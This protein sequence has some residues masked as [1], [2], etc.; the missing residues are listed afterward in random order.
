LST[1]EFFCRLYTA[2]CT[3]EEVRRSS[4]RHL[5]IRQRAFERRTRRQEAHLVGLRNE[6]RSAFGAD[7][8]DPYE[9]THH[10]QDTDASEEAR[11]ALLRQ[12]DVDDG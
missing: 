10:N 12:I 4:L 1:D 11:R 9:A 5:L 8:I 3:R 7:P 2:G 6:V